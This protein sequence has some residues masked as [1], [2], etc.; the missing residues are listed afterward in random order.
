MA[1][2]QCMAYGG[3]WYH[4]GNGMALFNH[5]I[6]GESKN[7][8]ANEGMVIYANGNEND[9]GGISK[10]WRGSILLAAYKQ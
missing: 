10:T 3:V 7:N 1:A 2:C 9:I 5:H 4:G 8:R 6:S